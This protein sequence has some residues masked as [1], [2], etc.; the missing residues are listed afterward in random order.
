MNDCVAAITNTIATIRTRAREPNA[1]RSGALVWVPP[2]FI[3]RNIGLS[4]SLVRI[5][6]E[7][8]S[9]TTEMRNGTRQPHSSNA[10]APTTACTSSCTP[11]DR[12][13]ARAVVP[14]SQP[15]KY[16]RCRAGAYSET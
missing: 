2:S 4:F 1:S 5:H 15:T 7:S 12:L 11:S 8:A 6:T 9:G 13:K 3:L 10:S 14:V 16:A